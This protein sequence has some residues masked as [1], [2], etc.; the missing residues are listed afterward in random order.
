V[1]AIPTSDMPGHQILQDRVWGALD[2]CQE[3][4]GVDFKAPATWQ[5]VKYRVIRTAMAMGNLRDGGLIIIGVS[6]QQ[7]QW[8]LV[9]IN[10][11]HLRSYDVDDMVD[12]VNRYASPP[13]VLDI[14]RVTYRNGREFLVVLAR[15]FE[16]TPHVCKRNSPSGIALLREGEIYVRPPGKAQTVKVASA[17][18][19]HDLLELAAEKRARRMIGTCR[20]IGVTTAATARN[21]FEREAGGL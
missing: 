16:H 20:R 14:V 18:E 10:A 11:S 1:A 15:E 8:D 19:L 3:S 5:D 7:R 21:L 9:G 2:R 13:M 12:A 4:E 6:E 17:D